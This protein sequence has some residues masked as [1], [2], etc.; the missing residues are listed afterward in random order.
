LWLLVFLVLAVSAFGRGWFLR[1]GPHRLQVV[2]WLPICI[3]SAAGLHRLAA[4]RPHLASATVIGLV[5]CGICTVATAVLCFQGPFGR[6]D[7][8]G[9]YAKLHTEIIS[10]EDAAAMERL[11]E[12]RVLAMPPGSD[13]IVFREG[14]RVVYGIGSFNLAEQPDRLLRGDV[15]AFFTPGVA[16]GLRRQIARQWCAEYVYCSDTWPVPEQVVDEFRAAA[17]LDE[18]ADQGRAT[19]FKVQDR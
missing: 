16:D 1:F 14:N 15:E 19:V 11:A 4:S 9:P 6:Q 2:L 8:K 17:W 13:A 18:I 10:E 12:G 3:L 7:A 5:A